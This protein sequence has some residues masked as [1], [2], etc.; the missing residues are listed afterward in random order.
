MFS[1]T[2]RQSLTIAAAGLF[3][4]K[5]SQPPMLKKKSKL[6]NIYNE[7]EPKRIVIESPTKLEEH[8]AYAQKYANDALDEGK[9]HVNTLHSHIQSVENDIRGTVNEIIAEDEEIL[10]NVVYIG[11]AALAGTIIARN[12][13]ILLRFLTSTTLAVGASYYLLPKT[14]K[15]LCVQLEKLEHKYPELGKAH[16][17]VNETVND[18]KKQIDD[19]LSS[20]S[21]QVAQGKELVKNQ[22]K[23]EVVDSFTETKKKVESMYS[24]RSSPGVDETLKKD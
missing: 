16:A 11:V 13:N 9:T 14:S 24:T 15:N 3:L 20:L 5:L 22:V 10:P 4:F 17:S 12:R 23:E 18:V 6:P 19:T 7:P 2:I 1:P 8:V 21:G